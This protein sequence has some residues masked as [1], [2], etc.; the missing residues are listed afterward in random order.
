MNQS[1]A[2]S[3]KP[4]RLFLLWALRPQPFRLLLQ[5]LLIRIHTV[6]IHNT[7]M[8]HQLYRNTQRKL[9]HLLP[10]VI[11]TIGNIVIS[12]IVARGYYS[13]FQ[14]KIFLVST[15]CGYIAGNRYNYYD[16]SINYSLRSCNSTKFKYYVIQSKLS[17]TDVT[18]VTGVDGLY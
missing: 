14:N 16:I 10:K 4:H 11:A 18:W 17:S 2:H 5:V 7:M 12:A 15:S 6:H 9:N 3:H 13:F 8:H 1:T